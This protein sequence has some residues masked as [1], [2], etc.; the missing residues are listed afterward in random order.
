M[1]SCHHLGSKTPL[2]SLSPSRAKHCPVQWGLLLLLSLRVNTSPLRDRLSGLGSAG[3]TVGFYDLKGFFPTWGVLWYPLSHYQV[4][5]LPLLL[6]FA[7]HVP[8]DIPQPCNCL[9]HFAFCDVHLLLAQPFRE[10]G[11]LIHMFH[12]VL[13]PN[14]NR[15][16]TKAF[17]PVHRSRL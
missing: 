13:P 16:T 17:L 5:L 7:C 8:W 9:Q 4:L 10:G 15:S 3:L 12:L 6:V 2:R 14:T 11:R 1:E